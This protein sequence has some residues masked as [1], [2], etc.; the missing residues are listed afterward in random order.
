MRTSNRQPPP[1]LPQEV[2]EHSEADRQRAGQDHSEDEQEDELVRGHRNTHSIRRQDRATQ[3][4]P[5][6]STC[7]E[8]A[9][10]Q[11]GWWRTAGC[12]YAV[13]TM[14]GLALIPILILLGGWCP[15][16]AA[17]KPAAKLPRAELVNVMQG[18]YIVV[19]KK[20]DLPA[21]YTGRLSFRP[22]GGTLAF[23]RTVDGRTVRGIATLELTAFGDPAPVLRMRFVQ[24]GLHLEATLQWMFDLDNYARFTGYVYRVDGT[25]TKAAGLEMLFPAEPAVRE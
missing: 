16:A 25:T 22:R 5:K 7:G 1:T 6:Q 2:A 4:G 10:R 11:D 17:A 24:D 23:T 8:S 19:G 9:C 21:T 18:D 20:P 15:A 13:P 12:V 14:R 3:G